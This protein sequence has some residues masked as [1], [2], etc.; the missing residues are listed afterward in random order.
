MA[1]QAAHP[2]ASPEA[3]I[4]A[5]RRT[6]R[7]LRVSVVL[8]ALLLG[9]SLVIEMVWGTGPSFGTIS[10]YYYSPVRSVLVG[11]LVAMSPALIAL[12]GR[13]GW[14][15]T[16]LSLAGMVIPVVAFVPASYAFG[17]GVCEGDAEKC[18]PP[19][20]VPSV[21]NNVAALLVVGAAGIAFAWWNSR[22]V[23]ERVARTGLR[24]ATLVWLGFFLWFTLGHAS[25]LAGAHYAAAVLFFV[26]IAGVAYF[27]GRDVRT[28]RRKNPHGPTP[29][30][31]SR[32]YRIISLLMAIIAV[33][34]LLVYLVSVWRGTVLW[35][36]GLFLVEAALLGLFVAFWVLQ[37]IEN[38]DEEAVEAQSVTRRVS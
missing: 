19:D 36:S 27:A 26:L 14:E 15:D 4:D 24:F 7:Y 6:Y 31:F 30:T 35:P 10:G 29:D 32:L 16:L 9:T 1:G 33:G 25:F 17:P 20:L 34:G 11:T 23:P 8:M 5:T 2:D 37:T 12:K 21:D 13:P 28:E 22:D 38:W 3:L 18:I